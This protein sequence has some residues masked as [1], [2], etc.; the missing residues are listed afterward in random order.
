M[1]KINNYIIEK[2]KLDKKSEYRTKLDD[3]M[4]EWERRMQTPFG[5]CLKELQKEVIDLGLYVTEKDEL[6]LYTYTPF[7]HYITAFALDNNP[8]YTYKRIK[9]ICDNWD[10]TE[11]HESIKKLLNKLKSL[12]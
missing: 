9:E 7:D 11:N 5:K 12:I 1:K 10:Y 4:D 2:L 3:E 8:E 6:G